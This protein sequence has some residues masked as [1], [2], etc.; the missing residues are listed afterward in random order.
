[1][2]QIAV[3]HANQADMLIHYLLNPD[4]DRQNKQDDYYKQQS[5]M[6][7]LSCWPLGNLCTRFSHCT[8]WNEF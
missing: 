1:M 8:V 6:S 7:T 3:A 2:M 5:G 4:A